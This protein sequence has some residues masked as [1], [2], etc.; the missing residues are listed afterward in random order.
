M[1]IAWI[2]IILL[3]SLSLTAK[4][5]AMLKK[6]SSDVVTLGRNT[7][8]FYDSLQIKASRHRITR[9]MY[10][11]MICS[12]KQSD[13]LGLQSYEYY[14]S[15]ENKI[16]GTITIKSLEVFGPDFNDTSKTTNIWIEKTANT[17]HSKS[18]LYVI[19]K[20]LWI[21]EGQTLDPNLIMD[22]ERLLRSLPYL[23]DVRFIIKNNPFNDELV[24][25][26][27]LTQDVFSFGISGKFGSV[28]NGKIGIYD[29][30]VLGIGHEIGTTIVANTDKYPH[31][32][33][34]AYYAVNNVKGNFI[35]FSAG[36][37][38]T[39]LREGFFVSLN[40]DFLRPQSVYAGVL[41]ALR[42]FRSDRITLDD[43][44][45]SD[46]TLNYVFLDGWY[47]R[48]LRLGINP[49]DSRFQMTISGRIRYTYFYNRPLPDLDGH[50]FFANSTFYLG[51]LS[52]SRRSYIRDH[53]VYSYG[54]TE[55]IPKGY[56]HELVLGYDHNEFGDRLYTHLFFSTGNLFKYRPFYFYTSL[57]VGSYWKHT[58]LEQGMVDFKLNFISPLFNVW[59]VRARQFI[60]LNY[61]VG[62]NRFEIEDLLLRNN[63]GIRGFGSRI[64]KGKQRLTLNVENV[65]FQKKS[66]LNFQSALFTFFDVGIVGPADQYIF[67]QTYYAGI[68]VG[69]RIRSENLIFKTI[70]LRLAYYPNHPNDV[71]PIGIIL[72]DVSKS[73]LYNFQPRGPEPLRFE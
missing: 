22:N 67:K 27:I 7:E 58:G 51:G 11:W 36:Y 1:R 23:K 20:N 48:R 12:P 57:G 64:E 71:N 62:M 55:D 34:E 29:K 45:I 47:G 28:N 63:I 46:S 39:Y 52:F 17:L 42:G 50:Q 21:K 49:D 10:D 72:D 69:L 66:I 9:L 30:N 3:S 19:R 38:N 2:I 24:D 73:R 65:F 31:V 32:G 6:D 18:D 4:D 16:I 70:Q 53:L 15:F 61:T 44:T 37:A 25:I 40:R 56:L 35:N 43:C 26:L 5:L 41:T 33:F 13:N 60:K 14:K 8:S 59:N 68:G 54:L